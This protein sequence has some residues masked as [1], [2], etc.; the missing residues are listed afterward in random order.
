MNTYSYI[1]KLGI[2]FIL[3]GAVLALRAF[4]KG[5]IEP[6]ERKVGKVQKIR[7]VE[8]DAQNYMVSKVF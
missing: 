8:D 2:V 5:T 3:S 7:F 1:K 4:G 6:I